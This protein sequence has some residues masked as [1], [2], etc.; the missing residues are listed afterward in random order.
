MQ[1]QNE[2]KKLVMFD[3]DGVLINTQHL[4]NDFSVD[5]I[6]HDA[7]LYLA[8]KYELAIVSS[9]SNKILNTFLKK[10]NLDGCFKDVLGY[11][12]HSSKVVR[13]N[14]LLKKYNI[15]AK[16]SVLITDTLGD[17]KEANEAGAK[18]IAV[19]WGLHDHSTLANGNPNAIIENPNLLIKTI[20]DVLK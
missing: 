13:I 8:D 3:F 6:L 14:S 20:E 11:E 10:E 12:E 1:T 15:E 18:S 4:D 19:L 9:A 16:D 2:N 5:D 17:L 7:V